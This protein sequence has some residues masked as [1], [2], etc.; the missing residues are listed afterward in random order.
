[1]MRGKVIE[2]SHPDD[3]F[4]SVTYYFAQDTYNQDYMHDYLKRMNNTY[5]R[6]ILVGYPKFD[7]I[8]TERSFCKGAGLKAV[9]TPRWSEDEGNCNFYDYGKWIADFFAE[10]S[11]AELL[12]RP[13]PQM[14]INIRSSDD[15]KEQRLES[16]VS[17]ITNSRHCRMDT[18]MEY[19]PSFEWSDCMITDMTSLMGD[20]FLTG[21]PII[22]CH[23]V[24]IFSEA[25]KNISDG[26]YWVKNQEELEKT[27]RML[28]RGED[29][30][31]EKRQ[32]IIKG[33]YYLPEKGAGY[34]IK[35][36]IKSD[37]Q[38]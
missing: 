22:Y 1:M 16:L 18:D 26:F 13:H 34:A 29:P 21:K 14:M 35:E 23:K 36:F 33:H 9:W 38:K 25:G 37:A 12:F 24:D 4:Q 11:N 7:L 10:T 6:T 20:Y 27:L 19:T 31:F 15:R 5:T 3:F 8:K 28:A 32:Q 30:L 2:G 17:Y